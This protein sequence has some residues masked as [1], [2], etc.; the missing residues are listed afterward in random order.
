MA[1]QAFVPETPTLAPIGPERLDRI[2][3]Q[4]AEIAE[5]YDRSAEFPVPISSLRS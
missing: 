4:L 3:R 2:T 1:S 5:T